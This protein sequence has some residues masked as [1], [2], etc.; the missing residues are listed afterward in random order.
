VIKSLNLKIAALLNAV[1]SEALIR[2][3]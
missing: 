3:D 1:N 2:S